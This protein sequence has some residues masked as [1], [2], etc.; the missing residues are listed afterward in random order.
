MTFGRLNAAPEG[1][2]CVSS[3]ED[4]QE[5]KRKRQSHN[6]WVVVFRN[7][8]C[9]VDILEDRFCGNFDEGV[10]IGERRV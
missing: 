4:S 6:D 5:K 2:S 9:F 7:N 3:T 10:L 8:A 1:G